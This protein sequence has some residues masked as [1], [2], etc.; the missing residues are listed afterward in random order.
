MEYKIGLHTHRFFSA[1]VGSSGGS[2][3]LAP[4]VLLS[5]SLVSSPS[6]ISILDNVTKSSIGHNT[7]HFQVPDNHY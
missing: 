1:V 2:F 6:L 5:S 3:S 4:S 7:S